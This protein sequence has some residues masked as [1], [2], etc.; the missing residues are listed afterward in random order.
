MFAV[1]SGLLTHSSRISW[2]LFLLGF[3]CWL[4]HY[5]YALLPLHVK[6]ASQEVLQLGLFVPAQ[7]LKTDSHLWSSI[8][9]RP[10]RLNLGIG[11]RKLINQHW[12]AGVY[13][14]WNCIEQP[15]EPLITIKRCN[16]GI[17]IAESQLGQLTISGYRYF[18]FPE[19]RLIK[20]RLIR[21]I[22]GCSWTVLSNISGSLKILV[23]GAYTQIG[24]RKV[25]DKRFT[26][27]NVFSF[28]A[29]VRWIINPQTDLE[30]KLVLGKHLYP[31]HM[32]FQIQ[33]DSNKKKERIFQNRLRKPPEY[34]IPYYATS[35]SL[36]Q[37]I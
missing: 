16:V 35:N 30:I 7:V 36:E 19:E 24:L 17:E 26:I 13:G 1:L 2:T 5:S 20:Y 14:Y 27:K 34:Y 31:V 8:G 29:G 18:A 11:Y 3:F 28:A 21:D 23:S 9:L 25:Q 32:H 4:P 10:L 37:K 22:G 15:I 33:L 6:Y 12:F